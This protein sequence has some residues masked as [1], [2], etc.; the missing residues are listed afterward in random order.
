MEV[1]CTAAWN[2][3]TTSMSISVPSRPVVAIVLI[4]VKDRVP[5][6]ITAK[7]T[8]PPTAAAETTPDVAPSKAERRD[9]VGQRHM[10]DARAHPRHGERLGARARRPRR[11]VGW[12]VRSGGRLLGSRERDVVVAQLLSERVKPRL[13]RASGAT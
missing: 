4:V 11:S 9:R 8:V 1:T 10:R 7:A 6:A 13:A 2:T 12:R 3:S 5:P